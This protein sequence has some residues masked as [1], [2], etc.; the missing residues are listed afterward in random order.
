MFSKTVQ[1]TANVSMKEIRK[2]GS[3]TATT[4]S[5]KTSAM[6]EK[7]LAKSAHNY[8]PLPVVLS[9]GKG[10]NVWDVDDKVSSGVISFV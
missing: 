9:R 1:F 5:A 7:E 3:S 8:H 4:V 2:F 6:I 10:V